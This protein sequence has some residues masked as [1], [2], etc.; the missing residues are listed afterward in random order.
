[1]KH[2]FY[3]LMLLFLANSFVFAQLKE[4]EI[5]EMPHPEVPIV[6]ANTEF[7][8]DALIIVYSSLDNLNFRSS[9]GGLDK[10]N[11]NTRANRYEILVKPLKQMI[12]VSSGEYMEQKIAT[13]N[14]KPKQDFY[15]KVEEK[16]SDVLKGKGFLK[17]ETQPIG[18]EIFLNGLQLMNRTPFSQEIPAGANRIMLRKDRYVDLDT[19]IRIKPNENTYFD[20]KMKP[21]W[22]ELYVKTNFNDALISLNGQQKGNGM[23]DYRG[24]DF[25]LKPDIYT[26]SI[27]K[28]KY[29]TYNKTLNLRAGQ[30]ENL[31][32]QLEPI[33]GKLGIVSNPP[34]ADVILNGKK[35]G[36]TPY[37][38]QLIIG[39]YEVEVVKAGH[40][41]E[42]F[43]F[44]M[45]DGDY[46][47]Y[48][49]ELKNYSIALNPLKN[50]RKFFGY[51]SIA[52]ALAGGYFYYSSV[53]AYAAY[54]EAT[55]KA[56]KLRKQVILGD[57]MY[58]TMI[59]VA[60]AAL[61][62]TISYSVKIRRLKKEWGLVAAPSSN[63]ANLGIAYKF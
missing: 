58:P 5:T 63:G 53:T 41:E 7:G 39:N 43:S 17:I 49:P 11:Y 23:V 59:G 24:I 62:P 27:S 32:I 47:E 30:I 20:I 54:P 48:K 4:F 6:Q 19:M 25:G 3:T 15:Y 35:V 8:D 26:L 12:L 14:P 13:I 42:K 31:D 33:T 40:K 56:E 16:L 60:V 51:F 50:K 55:D 28:E 29:R 34:N 61:I 18:C 45:R 36:T 21:G 46:K 38:S 9:V 37:N 2:F 57:I 44:Q 52:S 10:Q 22:A 1:M